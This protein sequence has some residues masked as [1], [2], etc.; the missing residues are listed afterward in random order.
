MTTDKVT[1]FAGP[2]LCGLATTVHRRNALQPRPVVAIFEPLDLGGTP[3]GAGLH[4]AMTLLGLFMLVMRDA[5]KVS[6]YRIV[7]EQLEVLM[8]CT[9]IAFNRQDVL[10]LAIDQM[11]G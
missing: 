8:E 7:Q 9:L 5:G 3:R 2:L 4:T 6:L 10:A 1:A 11:L